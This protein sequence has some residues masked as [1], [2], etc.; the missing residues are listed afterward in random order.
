MNWEGSGNS[1]IDCDPGDDYRSPNYES[2]KWCR[3][4]GCEI[5]H[6]N[7]CSIS[8]VCEDCIEEYELNLNEDE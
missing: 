5:N 7:A 4:C 6:F 1:M 8:E 2:E 3:Y